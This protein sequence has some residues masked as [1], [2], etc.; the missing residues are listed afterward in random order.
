MEVNKQIRCAIIT[1]LKIIDFGVLMGHVEQLPR[2]VL[3]QWGNDG[4]YILITYFAI[5]CNFFPPIWKKKIAYYI[6]N[7]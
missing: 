5:F 1:P 2:I 6:S 7:S 3:I 4:T